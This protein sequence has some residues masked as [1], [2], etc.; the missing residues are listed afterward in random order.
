MLKKL[1]A[2]LLFAIVALAAA[3][4][5][6][7][8]WTVYDPSNYYENLENYYQLY[9]A[10]A[11]LLQQYQQAVQQYQMFSHEFTQSSY[12]SQLTATNSR[13]TSPSGFPLDNQM[14]RGGRTG[15]AGNSVMAWA[16]ALDQGDDMYSSQAIAENSQPLNTPPDPDRPQIPSTTAAAYNNYQTTSALAQAGLTAA[17]TT[18]HNTPYRVA[19]LNQLDQS[20]QDT[21]DQSATSIAQKTGIA[22]NILARAQLDTNN[23]LATQVAQQSQQAIVQNNA[24]AE[25]LQDQSDITTNGTAVDQ[26]WTGDT[27]SIQ[28]GYTTLNETLGKQV[29]Q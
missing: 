7:A 18:N 10:N 26:S 3:P 11:N 25:H 28:G 20:W 6:H 1:Y 24:L 19:A 12:L 16:Q 29:Q 21:S 22:T 27:G 8:Q 15:Q 23:L 5:A 13:A 9:D 17:G 14:N 4:H 2:G